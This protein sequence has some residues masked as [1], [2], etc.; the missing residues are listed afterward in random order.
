RGTALPRAVLLSIGQSTY[1]GALM[2]EDAWRIKRYYRPRVLIPVSDIESTTLPDGLYWL[3]GAQ[4]GV[5]RTLLQYCDRR[6]T[7]VS[8]Y[9]EIDYLAPDTDQWDAV[10]LFLG[11][12]EGALMTSCC[13]DLVTALQAIDTTLTANGTQL[14]AI[15]AALEDQG[16]TLGT[17]DTSLSSIAGDV[18]DI[19]TA[20]ECIC[21]KEEQ[22]L[23]NVTVSP[24]W[25]DYPG[26]EDAFDWSTTNPV[27]TVTPQ[28]DADACAL[29][30]A[31]YQSGF[32]WMT[33]FVLPAFRFGFDKLIPAA[34]AGIA[35]WTGGVALPA[36]IGVYAMAELIQELIELGYD[37]AEANIENWLYT[38]KQDIVCPLYYGLKDGGTS[39]DLWDVVQDDLVDPSPDLSAG[40]KFLVNVVMKYWGLGAATVAKAQGSAWYTSILTPGYCDDCE[41]P[42]IIGSDWVAMPIS[43]E[44]G[45]FVIDHPSGSSWK[46]KCWLQN[47]PDGY[48]V[49]GMMV[50]ITR[51]DNGL[52]CKW[53]NGVSAGCGG[54]V[55][56][57]ND[58]S[59]QMTGV[60]WWYQYDDYTHDDT[61]VMSTLTPGGTKFAHGIAR[62]GATTM[63]EALLVGYT[64]TDHVEGYFRYIVYAG[65]TPPPYGY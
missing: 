4:I 3:T 33:E 32:E 28:A 22:V 63:S 21:A 49:V 15:V 44:D 61:E 17:M 30:Q 42:P 25:P 39:A 35:V 31:W 53:V 1:Q 34:A 5:L 7:W 47:V 13:E 45:F 29:A 59:D 26:A 38:H 20:L 52:E 40:D 46:G 14:A 50:E 6:S 9:R 41:E 48:T 54:S 16:V 27:T 36:A 12:L 23:V 10:Q 57:T 62:T 24:D 51:K 65:T 58:T 37:A 2:S 18:P 55:S 19:V 56:F 64:G 60:G 43:E 11:D 8:E